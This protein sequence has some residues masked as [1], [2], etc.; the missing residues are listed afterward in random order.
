MNASLFQSLLNIF[1]DGESLDASTFYISFWNMEAFIKVDE[2]DNFQMFLNFE[3]NLDEKQNLILN[4]AK[5]MGLLG[6]HYYHPI[7]LSS[8]RVKLRVLQNPKFKTQFVA[9]VSNL[10][11]I[12]Y[13]I[14]FLNQCHIDMTMMAIQSLDNINQKHQLI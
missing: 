13:S 10:D 2:E 4:K 5:Q 7:S 3:F 9:L 8:Q 1:P 12:Q 6:F 11:E 14:K